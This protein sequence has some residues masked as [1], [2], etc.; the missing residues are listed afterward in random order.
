MNHAQKAIRYTGD[1]GKDFHRALNA[2]IEKYLKA[3]GFTRHANFEMWAK[4][5]FFIGSY[6][7][8][9]ALLTFCE[10]S[11][12]QGILLALLLGFLGTGIALNVGHDASHSNFSRYTFVNDALYWISMSSLGISAYLWKIGHLKSHHVAS[13]VPPY[14]A[15][16]D[17]NPIIRYTTLT[18]WK[19]FHRYQH[20]YGPFLYMTYTFNWVL[21]RDWKLLLRKSN[22][23]LP[24]KHHPLR[25]VE[26][27]AVKI[28]YFM[29]MIALPMKYSSF[30][31][32]QIILGYVVMH[33]VISLYVSAALFSTHVSELAEI[34]YADK[35]GTLPHSFIEHQFLTVT[36]FSPTS[37]TANFL[38]GGFNAHLL[39]HLYP[40]L[41]SIHSP[42]LS[43]IL[44]EVSE[45]HGLHYRRTNLFSL[46]AAHYLYLRRMGA[47][48]DSRQVQTMSGPSPRRKIALN[49]KTSRRSA[50]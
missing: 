10:M 28:A 11:A 13:N 44:I 6:M 17:V 43:K 39:H 46:V 45:E 3:R 42:E 34:H 19:P 47:S 7:I 25:F 24:M 37:S 36:D 38:V 12:M 15:G 26:L 49:K 8:T 1:R 29:A 20:L 5:F 4:A 23:G 31:P 2:R 22:W 16:V 14:D 21:F 9:W 18:P 35:N 27:A 41:N 32:G 48:A 50:G 40:R 30:T 33:A